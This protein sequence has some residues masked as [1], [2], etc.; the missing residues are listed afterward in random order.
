[1]LVYTCWMLAITL[2]MDSIF[3]LIVSPGLLYAHELGHAIA[4]KNYGLPV[5]ILMKDGKRRIRVG[6]IPCFRVSKTDFKTLYKSEH[7]GAVTI[8]DN[9]EKLLYEQMRVITEAGP[10]DGK[11][12][13]LDRK[14]QIP[15][16]LITY[17][18]LLCTSAIIEKFH[19]IGLSHLMQSVIIIITPALTQVGLM[20]FILDRNKGVK[21]QKELD[22]FKKMIEDAPEGGTYSGG[23]SDKAKLYYREKFIECLELIKSKKLEPED[24]YKTILQKLADFGY[25]TGLPVTGTMP[26][27]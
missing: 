15:F 4:A 5:F 3:I 21:P 11:V 23:V 22:Q 6:E 24:S 25:V 27:G 12:W 8:Y 1:M 10:N 2:M 16:L 14:K 9:G 17:T 20:W 18:V 26:K 7:A 13:L 19:G